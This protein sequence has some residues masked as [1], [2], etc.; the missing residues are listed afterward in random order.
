MSRTAPGQR[1]ILTESRPLRYFTFFLFYFGQGLPVGL[2]V[3]AIPAWMAANGVDDASVGELVAWAYVAWTYKFIVAAFMDRFTFLAMG[4]RRIWLI[5]AQILMSGGFI[6][7]ALLDPGPQDYLVLVAV[8]VLVMTGAATQ[9]VAVDGL[10]VDILP[11]REQGTASAFMF[12]GQSFG[13]AMAAAGSG[14]GL[15][16]LGAQTTFLLFIPV[17]LIPTIFA[18]VMREHRGEKLLPWT[19]GRAS[20]AALAVAT[21]PYFG[22]DGQLMITLRS[23]AK[24]PSLWLIF[25]QSLGRTSGGIITPLLPILGTGFLMMSTAQYTSTVS[26]ADLLMAFV[27]LGAGSWLVLKL[28]ARWATAVNALTM[29]AVLVFLLLGQQFWINYPVFVGVLAVWSLL[30]VLNSICSNPLRMQLS[31]KRVGATQFTIYNSLANLPVAVGAWL[32]GRLGGSDNLQLTLGVAAGLY[33]ASA[34]AYALLRMPVAD[35]AA[36]VPPDELIPVRVD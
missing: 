2:T 18:I 5:G 3:T 7:A 30:V 32:M 29:G 6:C 11:E 4:R 36:A 24:G 35:G 16:Y 23:L 8:T 21:T 14:F 10:A 1:L 33:I 15:Q 28:G 9:D 19:E 31:D 34:L 12:G 17:L 26:T 22:R 13:A 20:P 27:S 25:A